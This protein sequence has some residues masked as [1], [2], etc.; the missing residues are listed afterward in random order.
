MRCITQTRWN[1]F[2]ARLGKT[3]PNSASSAARKYLSPTQYVRCAENNLFTG[4]AL[5]IDTTESPK[6]VRLEAFGMGPYAMKK[7]K[8]CPRCGQIAKRT[9]LVCYACKKIL[10][11]KTL[12]D[13]YK[14]MHFCCPSCD[15]PL[16]LDTQYCPHC[17][18]KV[19]FSSG[20]Q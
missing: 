9:S 16:T 20:E 1:A 14:M 19:S 6:Y 15:I 3:R 17:G 2:P 10:T 18:R 4:G 13:E 5:M 12:F 8:I 7:I 11:R